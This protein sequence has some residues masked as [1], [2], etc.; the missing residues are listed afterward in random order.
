M[1][2]V[3]LLLLAFSLVLPASTQKTTVKIGAFLSL[4]GATSTY[5]VSAANA[6]QMAVE[7]I[8][9][10]GGIKGTLISLEIEDDHSNTDEVPGI[11]DHLI[12][13]HGVKALLA[14]PV[15]T[16]ALAC[17]LRHD[18][19]LTRVNSA[20]NRKSPTAQSAT[21]LICNSLSCFGITAAGAFIIKSS[22]F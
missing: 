3:A 1:T 20:N 7:E 13:E 2:R 19:K 6:I 4:T 5:G 17:P 21:I 8:N 22:A 14:E 15:S 9:T 16:R 10:T 12:K 11:V 18:L